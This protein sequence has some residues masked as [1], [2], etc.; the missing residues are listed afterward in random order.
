MCQ[1]RELHGPIRRL[2]VSTVQM[3]GS[4]ESLEHRDSRIGRRAKQG[5]PARSAP[6]L[7]SGVAWGNSHPRGQQIL[8]YR[9]STPSVWDEQQQSQPRHNPAL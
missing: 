3:T 5:L 6:R 8:V 2:I 1:G 9:R 4:F 7:K